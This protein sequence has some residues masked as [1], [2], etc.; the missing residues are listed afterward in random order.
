MT[1]E[2][3]VFLW[4]FGESF[5]YLLQSRLNYNLPHHAT[6]D[7]HTKRGS[8]R[9]TYFDLTVFEI[10]TKNLQVFYKT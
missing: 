2:E 6:L 10:K 9:E 1:I 5:F 7:V 8:Q 3:G 4:L